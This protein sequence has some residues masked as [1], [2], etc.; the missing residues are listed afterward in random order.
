MRTQS[1][2]DRSGTI[3][4]DF[5]QSIR[6]INAE[7][8]FFRGGK[9]NGTYKLS[10]DRSGVSATL[11]IVIAAV[12]IIAGVTV[13]LI[14]LNDDDDRRYVLGTKWTYDIEGEIDGIPYTGTMEREVIGHNNEADFHRVVTTRSMLG[15]SVT[16]TEYRLE[17]KR[18]IIPGGSLDAGKTKIQTMDGSTTVNIW[19]CF[20]DGAICTHYVKGDIPYRIETVSFGTHSNS[21][22]ANLT[23]YNIDYLESYTQSENVGKSYA[24]SD[25]ATAT[26]LASE[27]VADCKDGRYGV[28]Q[29]LFSED[30]EELKENLRLCDTFQ[31]LITG[32]VNLGE[33]MGLMTMDGN[34]VLEV[35]SFDQA[36]LPR[37]KYYV[38]PG[39][40][41]IYKFT[42]IDE[43]QDTTMNFV[44]ESYTRNEV[45]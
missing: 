1:I 37:I 4:D 12:I 8:G 22:T 20:V 26:T 36:L 38:D 41:I 31:G 21:Q 33:T 16:D 42:E 9:M 14:V 3:R 23:S 2:Y 45:E 5:K 13:Y 43:I 10:R 11:A 27:C 17:A 15:E 39:T 7:E 18:G 40:D 32:S 25:V 34:K 35:W 44:L 29:V 30:G 28:R 19:F 6:Y 24:Y